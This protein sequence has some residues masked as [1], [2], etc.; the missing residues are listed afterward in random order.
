MSA[1]DIS[2][3]SGSTG[4]NKQTMKERIVLNAKQGTQWLLML[5]PCSTNLV[6]GGTPADLTVMRTTVYQVTCQGQD[7]TSPQ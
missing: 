7:R 3:D 4:L 2:I 5:Q 1:S 6:T